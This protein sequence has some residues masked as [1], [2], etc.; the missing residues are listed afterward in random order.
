MEKFNKDLI[1]EIASKLNLDDIIQ[2][3]VTSPRF[4]DLIC[5][6]NIFWINSLLKE[7]PTI[8]IRDVTEY[9]KLY[10][11]LKDKPNLIKTRVTK[12]INYEDIPNIYFINYPDIIEKINKKYHL[13]K[14]DVIK[15]NNIRVN[16]IWNGE[17]FEVEADEYFTLSDEFEFPYFPP[18]YWKDILENQYLYLDRD[19]IK[20]A[21]REGGK[22]ITGRFGEK[23]LI[24]DANLEDIIDRPYSSSIFFDKKYRAYLV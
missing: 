2:L 13:R 18:N 4:N 6:S 5:K 7:F 14:G 23:Y 10:F 22:Y 16:Y 24:E 15:F 3:C 17:E 12:F 8:D 21:Y 11:Y 20:K 1:L 19:I 9:K